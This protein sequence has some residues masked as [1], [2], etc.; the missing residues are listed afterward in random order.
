MIMKDKELVTCAL[1][2][3]KNA[4]APYSK[5]KVG[6][7]LLSKSGGVYTGWNIEN[8]VL[9]INRYARERVAYL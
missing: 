9:R 6:A 2:S 3:M 8:A 1:K 7:A 4:Y 5:Y